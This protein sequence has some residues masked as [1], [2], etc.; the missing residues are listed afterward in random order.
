MP[1]VVISPLTLPSRISRLD[2][3]LGGGI[4]TGNIT[5]VY[6]RAG[7]GKT[8]LGLEF[9]LSALRMG[10]H[11]VYVNSEGSSPIERLEQMAGRP[12]QEL[13]DAINIIVPKDFSEQG[14][15]IEDLELYAPESTRLIVIDTLT[16]L[17]RVSLDDKKTN[18]AAHRE[19]NRQAGFLKGIAS[20]RG[21]AVL[22][23]N[24]VR[25]KLDGTDDFEPVAKNIMEYWSDVTL[26]LKVGNASSQRVVERMDLRSEKARIRLLIQDRGFA[27]ED[28]IQQE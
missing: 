25:A 12:Y 23:L 21:I 4:R 10:Y 7:S 24:Q 11:T 16:R 5:H 18:Y 3:M 27:L 1:L 28:N 17:Y 9:V 6:G 22:V 8:T 19:L 26:R 20:Q 15:I 2:L 13:V 14:E